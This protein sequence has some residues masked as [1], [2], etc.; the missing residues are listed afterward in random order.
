MAER[1]LAQTGVPYR[2]IQCNNRWSDWLL[3]SGYGAHLVL[4]RLR[5]PW[6]RAGVS[7]PSFLLLSLCLPST[8]FFF[9]PS[10]AYGSSTQSQPPSPTI[11]FFYASALSAGIVKPSSSS[12]LSSSSSSAK[13]SASV[14]SILS[15]SESRADLYRHYCAQLQAWGL[16]LES[17]VCLA[18]KQTEKSRKGRKEAFVCSLS[19]GLSCSD[20]WT[21]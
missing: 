6:L 20:H 4:S 17:E 16:T 3:F 12:S 9:L 8:P 21:P 15:H 5:L 10:S 11:P 2:W 7:C 14:S 18:C 19:F 13:V 1:L